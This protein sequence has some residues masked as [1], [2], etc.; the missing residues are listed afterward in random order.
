MDDDLFDAAES[1][2]L[3]QLGMAAAAG[4]RPAQLKLARRIATTLGQKKQFVTADDV[5]R[6]LKK[7]FDIDT[8]GPAAGSLFK[9]RSWAFSGRWRK[10][11]RK[12]NHS[13]MIRV[14]RYVERS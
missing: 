12:T 9:T 2:R 10:S 6:I 13:R 14:W 3:K 1:E 8:L 11:V 7:N 4:N 5:G